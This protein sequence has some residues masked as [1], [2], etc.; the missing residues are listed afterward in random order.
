MRD[1]RKRQTL[2]PEKKNEAII[3][4]EAIPTEREQL[5]A[6][7]FLASRNKVWSADKAG[8]HG[9]LEKRGRNL[10]KRSD[11]QAFLIKFGGEDGT[12]PTLDI[13]EEAVLARLAEIASK[14]L[15]KV[16][17]SH[18]I[19]ALKLIGSWL[20]MWDGEN[21]QAGKDKLNE[22]IAAFQAGPKPATEEQI[23]QQEEQGNGKQ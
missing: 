18:V 14:R 15:D 20:S 7:Y 6:L 4:I 3:D 2:L 22:L 21:M 16:S 9:D 17:T 5:F 10:L 23:S 1:H 13:T 8:Y 19:D 11:V 12:D